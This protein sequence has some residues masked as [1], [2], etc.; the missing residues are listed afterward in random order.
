MSYS[1]H[2]PS[3]SRVGNDQQ[4]VMTPLGLETDSIGTPG[5]VLLAQA[6]PRLQPQPETQPI[7]VQSTTPVM[8]PPPI[9][10]GTT[11]NTPGKY[12]AIIF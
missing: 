9:T 4:Q 12:I 10:S 3:T 8:V 2:T 5:P 7:S 6:L 1:Q 11:C